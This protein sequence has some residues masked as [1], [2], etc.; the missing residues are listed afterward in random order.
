MLKQ[1]LSILREIVFE[2][3]MIRQ[4]LGFIEADTDKMS[5]ILK[6]QNKD[7]ASDG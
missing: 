2:L 5:K 6:A 1:I 7:G 4:Y 3:T